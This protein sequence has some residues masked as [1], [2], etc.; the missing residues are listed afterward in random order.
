MVLGKP[1]SVAETAKVAATR[2]AGPL[3]VEG[4]PA[5]ATWGQAAAIRFCHDWQ[6]KN[7]DPERETAARLLWTAEFLFVKFVARYR[8]ITV[9]PDSDANGRRDHL[10]DRD[11]AEM[12]LQPHQASA[13]HYKEIEVSPNGQWID[14]DIAPGEKRDLQS[15]LRR[16]V[17]I[18]EE[19]KIWQA[20]LALPMKG[21]AEQ[22]DPVLSW[23]VNFFRVEG[24]SEPRF[25]S[26]WQPT[27]TSA[28][29]F[30]VPE[31]F[32]KLVFEGA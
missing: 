23:R 30:H 25:Y 20:E 14:L 24:P 26:A 21:L 16:R 15:G 10:W 8:S 18:D 9:F 11:V 6:G 29:N 3:D 2:A 32:G 31:C 28:P 7:S 12:F 5:E 27:G 13:R 4:F 17:R 1:S 19:N 22:F